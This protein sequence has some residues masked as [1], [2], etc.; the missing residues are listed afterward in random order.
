MIGRQNELK[1]LKKAY[2]SN[3]SQLVAIYGRR[4]IGKTYLVN[5]AFNHAFAFHHSGLKRGNLKEQLKQFRMSLRQH[6]SVPAASSTS[7]SV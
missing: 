4:R 7:D 2:D 1:V 6:L 3:E 5:E